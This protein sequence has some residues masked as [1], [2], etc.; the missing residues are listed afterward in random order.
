MIRVQRAN[1]VYE[2]HHDWLHSRFYYSFADY[3]DPNNI[4]FGPMRVL[5][6]DV[7]KPARGFGM[8]PHREMEIVSIVLSGHLAHEDSQGNQASTTFGQVQRMSA[9]TGIRHSEVNPSQSEDVN[10]LQ[11]WFV[12]DQPRLEPSYEKTDFSISAMKNQLLPVVS[13]NAGP[14]VAF[15]NQDLTISLADLDNGLTLDV[16]QEEGRRLFLFVID[17]DIQLSSGESLARRD[18]ARIEGVTQL[19]ITAQ[20]DSRLMVIDLP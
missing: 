4:T 18:A 16:Q 9:G 11:M 17:G 13:R 12:P 20:S 1:S 14:Q 2:A 8:H 6:D 3:Y 15:I 7:I 10:L 19:R 5:N